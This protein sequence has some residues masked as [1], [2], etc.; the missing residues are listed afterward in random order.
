MK[1][2]VLL[3]D[4]AQHV[5]VSTALVSYVLNNQK[6]GRINKETADRIRKAAQ[7]LNYQP[8]QL[9]KGLKTQK[10]LTIGLIVADIS[11]PFSSHIARIIEDEA[12][13]SGYT[14]IFGSSDENAEKM[15][16]LIN[17]LLNRQVEGLIIAAAENTEDQVQSLLKVGIPFVL[18]DRYFPG[19]TTN[20]VAIDNF[21]AGYKA[22]KHL[23]DNGYS[24]IGLVTYKTELFHLQERAN[25]YKRFIES[26]HGTPLIEEVSV[27]NVK[28]DVEKAVSRLL[29]QPQPVEAIFF[30]TNMLTIH[31][32]KHINNLGIKVPNELA[33]VGFDETD[34]FD[35]FYAPIT[36][37]RQPMEE[38]GKL[39]I[40]TL[41]DIIHNNTP[42]K[43]VNLDTELIIRTSSKAFAL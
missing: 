35:L 19:I 16:D 9:A 11:N 29:S 37:V 41:L 42:V 26:I 40:R 31:G 30:V 2:K 12:K 27:E 28:E 43:T 8:N 7:E 22:T 17:L 1:K 15:Q 21:A 24:R 4:I 36:H 32:I 33:V 18:I 20:Y 25:G 13:K 6:E 23:F 14:V 3:K 10:S 38:L 39:S 34:A 5:G